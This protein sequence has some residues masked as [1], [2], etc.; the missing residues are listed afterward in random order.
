[1]VLKKSIIDSIVISLYSRF[2][3][4]F[5][6]RSKV[7]N[8]FSKNLIFFSV[9]KCFQFLVSIVLYTPLSINP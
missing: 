1:M 2:F 3:E 9:D 7:I 5:I 4:I 8:L 6:T